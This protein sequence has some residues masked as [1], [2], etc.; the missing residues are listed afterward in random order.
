MFNRGDRRRDG[1]STK[2]E[3]VEKVADE[4]GIDNGYGSLP[5][6]SAESEIHRSN[7]PAKPCISEPTSEQQGRQLFSLPGD[8]LW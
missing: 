2:T 4:E 3:Q 8:R 7:E 6:I 5:Y 1:T